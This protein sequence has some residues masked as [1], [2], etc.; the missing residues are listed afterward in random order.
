MSCRGL[1]LLAASAAWLQ[2][3]SIDL[4]G[5]D[6]IADGDQHFAQSCAVGYCHGSEGTSARGPALRDREWNVHDLYRIT[7]EGLPGTSMP[8]WKGV[9]PDRAIWAITAYVL[10]LSSDPPSGADAVV[11]LEGTPGEEAALVPLSADAERGKALFSDLTRE[12]RCSV[13]HRMDGMGSAIGPNLALAARSK[14]EQELTQDIV[15]PNRSIAFGF[16]QVHLELRSG[17]PVAGVL[18][19]ETA[20][21]VRVYDSGAVPPPLRSVARLDIRDQR[22]LQGSAM[23]G[24]LGE[25]YSA[26]EIAA[27]VGY[28]LETA[29]RQR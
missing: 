11:M 28:L 4:A 8:G 10:S 15:D 26:E 6:L 14:S 22:T 21:R 12:R 29:G 20:D 18:A 27:I 19:G 5:P 7:A 25:T 17:E 1:F 24:D 2:A 3:E 23:P 9:I 13:C 16:E